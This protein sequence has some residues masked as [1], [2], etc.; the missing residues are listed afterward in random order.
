MQREIG[1]C[2]FEFVAALTGLSL[3]CRRAC[4]GWRAVRHDAPVLASIVRKCTTHQ[5]ARA[6]APGAASSYAEI[7]PVLIEGEKPSAEIAPLVE[8]RRAR[9]DCAW[10]ARPD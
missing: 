4:T 3:G 6:F 9:R 5:T 10:C 8:S 1:L 7:Y 2:S